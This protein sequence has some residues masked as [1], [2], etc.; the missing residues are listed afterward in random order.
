MPGSIERQHTNR[1]F[2]RELKQLRERLLAMG[3]RAEQQI[4]AAVACLVDRDD[5]RASKVIDDDERIDLDEREIDELAFAVIARRQP[6]ASD[7]RFVVFAL[8]IV[9]DLERIG[10]LAVNIAKRARDLARLD[11]SPAEMRLVELAVR[12]RAALKDALDA[13]AHSDVERAERV[14]HNDR[15]I[16]LQNTHLIADLISTPTEGARD[17]ARALAISS[18]SRYLERIGDHATNVAEMVIYSLRG[19][20]VR[21]PRQP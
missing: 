8:K 17:F 13:F 2:E 6:V 4:S 5:E 16:D 10:D 3:G 7:L 11:P 9:T 19:R 18:I 20:D 1:E 21:H 15:E 14:I 12:V